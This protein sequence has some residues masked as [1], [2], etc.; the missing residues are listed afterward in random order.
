MDDGGEGREA[1]W[2]WGVER[3]APHRG[4]PR[5]GGLWGGRWRSAVRGVTGVSVAWVLV[6]G[7]VGMAGC[8]GVRVGG[9][10][11]PDAALNE[12]RAEN[13]ELRAE[14]DRLRG[15]LETSRMEAA[16]LGRR[17]SATKANVPGVGPGDVPALARVEIDG[18]SGW[19]DGDRDGRAET[20]RVYVRTLDQRG[21]FLPVA[22]RAVVRV[23][24]V[25]AQAGAEA[26]V[27]TERV[28]EGGAWE[29]CYRSGLTGMHY[30]VEV[31]V[32]DERSGAEAPGSPGSP[33]TPGLV[34][35]GVVVRVTVLDAA[36]GVE[37]SA[38][39][40]VE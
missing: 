2:A 1:V 28:V 7:A 32:K 9:T 25:P 13:F 37:A 11:R 23:A 10:M 6:L 3:P 34:R 15:E 16:A 39:R 4:I 19:V 35:G 17:L 33:G 5:S 14:R 40:T 24:E 12:L 18:L 29:S 30:T 21:R 26:R 31:A 8:R 22:G 20:M 36:T 38:V 27:L